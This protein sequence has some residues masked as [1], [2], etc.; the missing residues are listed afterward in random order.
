VKALKRLI[1]WARITRESED[2]GDFPIQQVGYLGKVGNAVVWLPYGF[3]A[4]IPENNLALMLAIAGNPEARVVLPGSPKSRVKPVTAGEVVVFHPITGSKVH[5][6]ENGD[7]D[8][9]ATGDLNVTVAGDANVTAGG[10][11]AVT[12]GTTVDVVAPGEVKV[13]STGS[14]VN[15]IADSASNIDLD[16]DLKHTGTNVGF[17]GVTPAPLS[18][19]Y[20]PTNVTPDRAFDADAHTTFELADVLGTLIADLQAKGLIG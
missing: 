11:I 7:I 12:A 2:T 16:G 15:I 17:H 14:H 1:R 18:S 5:F 10:A 4:N 6:R 13:E 3:H 8:I 9:E 19:A 20:T